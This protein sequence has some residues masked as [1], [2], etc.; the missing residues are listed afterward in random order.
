MRRAKN[1]LLIIADQWRGDSLGVLGH[2]ASLTPNL[3]ALAC[4]G[5]L[6]RN[7]YGQSA[8]CGPARAS[9]L[10]GQYV[11][12][13]RVVANGVPLDARHPTL[14]GIARAGGIDAAMIGYT[15]TTPDPRTTARDDLRFAEIGHVMDGFRVFAHLDEVD[16]RNYFGW[17]ATRG[18]SLPADPTDIWL[19]ITGKPGP[20][21]AASGVDAAHSDTAW[22]G[23]H[24]LEFLRTTRA[25]R[26]WL[27]HLGFYRPHPPFVAPAPYNTIVPEHAIPA[28]VRAAEE[29]DEAAAHPMLAHWLASQ[30][31]GSYFHGA[32]G[33][34]AS[35]SD[36]D[37][38]ST[39]RAYYGLI[40]ELDVWIGRVLEELRRTGQYDNTLIIFTSDHGEQLGDHRLLGKLGWFDQSYHLPLIIRH[41]DGVR[42]R[43]VNAFTEAVDV[44]PTVLDWLD[45][46][47]PGT[48]N[49][50]T[51]GPWL[52]GAAPAWRDAVH[53]EYDLRGGWPHPASLPSHVSLEV[54]P[55]AA[56][57]TDRWKYVHFTGLPPILYDLTQDPHELRNVAGDPAYRGVL[58]EAVQR[59]LSWRMAHVDVGLTAVVASPDGLIER[60]L[61]A[62]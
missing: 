5:V 58:L 56:M 35:L 4:D 42:G 47:T 51:L 49:G 27:L 38:V 45:L 33:R 22:S 40:A 28:P 25:E 30:R 16:F 26:P 44:M 21:I 2:A 31:Q 23:E 19:P 37:I 53:F 6:F 39:R 1:V 12:N 29:A 14:A 20:T 15:T 57:R 55:M 36:A 60:A 17:I 32:D 52:A 34:V 7:H 8:P 11:M 13:H 43:V 59:M 61:P 3:D 9:L 18:G 41:P 50:T 24:A 54:G 46:A 48:C 62:R 10:T